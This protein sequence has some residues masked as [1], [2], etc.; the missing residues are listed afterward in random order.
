M[1]HQNVEVVIGRLLVD[2]RFRRAFLQWPLRTLQ[3]L[4]HLGFDFTDTEMQALVGT[5]RRLWSSM[6]RRLDPRLCDD[7]QLDRGPNDDH[8]NETAAPVAD[9]D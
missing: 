8:G 4:K 5:D 9:L 6:A 7:Q 1:S 3:M 2:E